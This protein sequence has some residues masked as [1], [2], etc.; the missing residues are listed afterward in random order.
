LRTKQEQQAQTKYRSI[1]SFFEK[2]SGKQLWESARRDD[3]VTSFLQALQVLQKF[4]N[5][6]LQNPTLMGKLA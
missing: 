5:S 6:Q 2:M 3:C 1:G 4:I